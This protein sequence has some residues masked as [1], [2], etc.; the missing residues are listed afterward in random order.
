MSQLPLRATDHDGDR[1]RPSLFALVFGF[2]VLGVPLIVF[3]ALDP[4][5]LVVIGAFAVQLA[6]CLI[7]VLWVLRA[8]SDDDRDDEPQ[9]DEPAAAA[10]ARAAGRT[11]RR[12][13]PASVL[14]RPPR[15]ASGSRPASA[16]DPPLPAAQAAAE[17]GQRNRFPR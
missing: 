11:V 7:G 4:T 8:F 10:A 5:T 2:T 12:R 16:P 3:V 13:Q 1:V 6:A 15:D 14:D 17:I 9:P